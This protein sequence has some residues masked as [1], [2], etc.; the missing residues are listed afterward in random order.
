MYEDYIYYITKG[1]FD[2]SSKKIVE[3]L[4][5]FYCD[6]T[7]KELI[8]PSKKTY[9]LFKEKYHVD[10]DVHIVPTGVETTRFDVRKINKKDVIDLK[11]E[12][13]IK[14]DDFIILY[15][16]RL[17]KE[18]NIDLLIES[19]SKITKKYKNAKLV[20]VGSGPDYEHYIELANKFKVKQKVIFTNAIPWEEIPIYY[21]IANIFVTA[22]K[23]E[24]Q[25]LTI[26]EA[27]ASSLP[28]VCIDDTSFN[29]VVIDNENGKVFND[30]EEYQKCVMDLI[31]N[32]EKLK[33]MK[34]K[35]KEMAETYSLSFYAD[36]ILE[37]YTKAIKS[38][39]NN[40][41]F[42]ITN[43]VKRGLNGK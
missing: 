27:M 16:G 3:Y 33:K 22:S 17:A 15:V 14:N 20:I 7:A 5:K 41:W 42:K 26:I 24:T 4:T 8:V 1:Y 21:A 35:A 13:G 32:K 6:K 2:R 23:T 19:H 11:K 36:R 34:I 29:N 38:G 18:K 40:F 28:V 25:G 39:N 30:K 43:V 37:V 12:L 10:K 9:N 31:L